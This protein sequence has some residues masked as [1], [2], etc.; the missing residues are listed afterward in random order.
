MQADTEVKQV[1]ET[2]ARGLTA[3]DGKA[4]AKHWAMPAFVLGDSMAM[5]ISSLDE[6]AKFM[7]GAKAQYQK[8]GITDTRPEIQKLEWITD[9]IAVADVRW[10]YLDEAGTEKGAE[11]SI[12]TLVRDESG[13]LKVRSVVMRGVEKAGA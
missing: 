7:G 12:Y 6:V 1:L 9:K 8:M 5:P 11:S 13:E 3:G 2:I 4:V 10:P